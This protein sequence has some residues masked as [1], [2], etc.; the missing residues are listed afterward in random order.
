MKEQQFLLPGDSVTTRKPMLL[1]TL[2]G[3]CVSVCLS[4]P[5][6]RTAGMNHYM[7]PDAPDQQDPGRYGDTCRDNTPPDRRRGPD[8]ASRH[9]QAV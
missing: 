9:R 7:L 5:Q 6:R 8:A 4:N 3:S 1:A 2:L